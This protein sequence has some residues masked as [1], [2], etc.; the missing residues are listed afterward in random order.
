M[1]AA[2]WRL[3][4][5]YRLC[6]WRSPYLRWRIETFAGLHAE[7]IGFIQFW[8]F[9]WANRRELARYLRWADSMNARFSS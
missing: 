1:I 8:R 2:A 5:G 9:V 6:P 3:T 4:K 7:R